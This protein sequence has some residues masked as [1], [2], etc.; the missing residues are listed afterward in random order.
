[1]TGRRTTNIT[2]PAE[3]LTDG[4]VTLRLP[5]PEA[6]DVA[7][8][9]GYIQ[10]GQLA[11]GWLPDIP[12]ETAQQL[13]TGWLGGWVGQRGGNRPAFVVT[14]AENPGFVGVVG[15]EERGPGTV[16]MRCGTA[17]KFRGQGLASRAARLAAQWLADQPGVHTVEARIY[18]GDRA[19]ERVAVKAG[20]ELASAST[21]SVATT[22]AVRLR[23]V[24][25]RHGAGGP[26]K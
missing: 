26:G 1:V 17:P 23:Y 10:E 8:I 20:F 25:K 6:G 16:A 22:G 18:Q 13:V 2:A 11:G 15:A 24:L 14:I 3:P 7:T 21:E 9:N 4:V 19:S 5:S 12:L